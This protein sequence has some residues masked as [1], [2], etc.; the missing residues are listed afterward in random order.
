M[1]KIE[2]TNYETSISKILNELEFNKKLTNI[3][4]IVI[5]PNL[6]ECA[7]PPTT[8]DVRCV[9]AIFEDRYD[10]Y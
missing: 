5:K 8:T 3:I 2:F 6:L 9:E 1:K 10:H 4:K 7:P